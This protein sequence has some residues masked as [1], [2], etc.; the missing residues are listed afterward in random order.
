MN[1]FTRSDF[2][3][4]Y[5]HALLLRVRETFTDRNRLIRLTVWICFIWFYWVS[6]SQCRRCR[7]H[8]QPKKIIRFN[9]N[10][11]S[12]TNHRNCDQWKK[13]EKQMVHS[14]SNLSTYQRWI[15][16]IIEKKKRW[17]KERS[18]SVAK[19]N[20]NIHMIFETAAN[21]YF[22]KLKRLPSFIL[23]ECIVVFFIF[24]QCIFADKFLLYTHSSFY[25][26]WS[27]DLALNTFFLSYSFSLP[28]SCFPFI[29]V[30]ICLSHILIHTHLHIYEFTNNKREFPWKPDAIE[31]NKRYIFHKPK[32]KY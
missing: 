27:W 5:T 2:L 13:W 11:K 23:R 14:N 3:L 29:L 8:S 31:W 25:M 1:V 7:R 30:Y 20:I 16:I 15:C 24:V 32:I 19:R 18:I 22:A 6:E 28:L 17:M 4:K 26:W 12:T 9:E 10:P 21:F